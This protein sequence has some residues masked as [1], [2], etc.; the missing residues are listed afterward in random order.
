[1]AALTREDDLLHGGCWWNSLNESK[2]A[3]CFP[4]PNLTDGWNFLLP[5]FIPCFLST[6]IQL[7]YFTYKNIY[8]IYIFLAPCIT[9]LSSLGLFRSICLLTVNKI[10]YFHQV[11]YGS[12]ICVFYDQPTGP[13]GAD[14]TIFQKLRNAPGCSA[15][16][17]MTP[18]T[19]GTVDAAPLFRVLGKYLRSDHYNVF[20][21]ITKQQESYST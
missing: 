18:G 14:V 5:R 21:I 6:Y 20:N 8:V 15:C 13:G 1:M 2:A 3:F 12:L 11:G 7:I 19:E 10:G 9:K 4:A 16:D 17:Y